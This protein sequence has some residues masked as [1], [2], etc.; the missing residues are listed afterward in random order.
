MREAGMKK[1][2]LC[3]AALTLA[4]ATSGFAQTNTPNIDKREAN[5]QK[6][7]EQGVKSG[8]L[9]Q[10]EAARLEAGQAKVEKMEGKARADGKV[11]R[12]ERK[13]IHQ[14]QDKESRRIH[15]LK[16]NPQHN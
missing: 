16:H 4:F 11:T 2:S 5:Q 7:I 6:R 8:A 14:A 13:R 10:G 12:Q 1:F 15:K 9:T 3:I